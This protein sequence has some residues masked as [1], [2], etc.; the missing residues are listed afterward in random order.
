MRF[1]VSVL[2]LGML[3][4]QWAMAAGDGTSAVGGGIGG[5]LEMSLASKWAAVPAQR[6]GLVSAEQLV[7][8]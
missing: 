7:G 3:G 6:L 1:I 4:T 2:M 8:L 5:A